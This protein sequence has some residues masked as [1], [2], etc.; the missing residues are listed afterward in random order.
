VGII[1]LDNDDYPAWSE[2]AEEMLAS[3]TFTS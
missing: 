1:A 2:T 3:F